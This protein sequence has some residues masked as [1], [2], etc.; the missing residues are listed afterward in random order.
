MQLKIKGKVA[1]ARTHCTVQRV[2]LVTD[3]SPNRQVGN[4]DS[5]MRKKMQTNAAAPMPKPML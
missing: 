3:T 2:A 5:R 1:T 4:G